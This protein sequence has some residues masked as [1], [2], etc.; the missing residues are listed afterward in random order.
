AVAAA[1]TADAQQLAP[2]RLQVTARWA[3][4]LSV[5]LALTMAGLLAAFASQAR[6]HLAQAERYALDARWGRM[7]AEA[8][9]IPCD[10]RVCVN[11]EEEARRYGEREQ[12]QPAK[13]RQPQSER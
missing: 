4:V 11:V 2:R 7:L 9:L 3:A 13:L 5:V 1:R 12:Y 8:D 10:G 6:R